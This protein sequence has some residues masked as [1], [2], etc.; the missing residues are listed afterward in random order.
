[1]SPPPAGSSQD[2][3]SHLKLGYVYISVRNT[4][5]AVQYYREVL[6]AKLLWR[7]QK[8]GALVAALQTQASDP[9]LLLNDH[10][11]PPRAE[12]V[13]IVD[14]AVVMH[15]RLEQRRARSLSAPTGAATG[16]MATFE[17]LDGNPL[18]I[19]DH[20]AIQTFQRVVEEQ[21]K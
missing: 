7:I 6:G 13:F 3:S 10:H 19:V 1:M 8:F 17:D 16:M 15:A 12:P 2:H 20:S 4:D 9:I 5:A 21:N 18:A 14:S 11:S